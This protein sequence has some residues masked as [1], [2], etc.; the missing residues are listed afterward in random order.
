M[1]RGTESILTRRPFGGTGLMVPPI[2]LGCAPLGDMPETFAYGVPEDQALGAIRA[3]LAS[4]LNY[5]DTAAL[6]GNGESER[7]V[8]LVLRELGGLPEGAVLQTKQGRD[9]ET[10]DFSGETVKRRFERSLELLGVEKVQIVYLHDAEWTTYEDAFAPGGPIDALQGYKEQGLIEYLGVASGPIDLEIRYVESGAFDAVITHNRYTLLNASAAPLF[11]VAVARGVAVLNAAPYGSGMLA[12]GPDSY[13][14]YAYQQAS[15]E[16]VG[17][18]RQM[19]AICARHGVPLA[20]AA[21]QF[22]LRDPRIANT[23]VGMSSAARIQS[24]IDLATVEIPDDLWDE[25]A[26]IPPSDADPEVDR[27]R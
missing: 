11:D 23:I 16:M 20:A 18:V 9:P 24:T 14:R 19:Q 8:G 7:R 25:L 21:L 2:S 3:A 15:D 13:P 12:K 10:N 5:I 27:Y 1:S 26:T 6:Y 4:P 17:R 22:S